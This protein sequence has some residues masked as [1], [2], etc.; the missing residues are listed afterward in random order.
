MIKIF[1]TMFLITFFA[2]CASPEV[3]QV[4]QLG[5]KDLSCGQ[6]AGEMADAKKFL[7]EARDA[8]GVTG[9]N[10]AA[11]LFFWPALLATY[12]NASEAI[13]AANERI[14]HLHNLSEQKGC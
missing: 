3:V 2:G 6:I 10:A 8:K 5:D 7:K 4:R 9:T 13:D 11:V 14:D 12:S 1:L